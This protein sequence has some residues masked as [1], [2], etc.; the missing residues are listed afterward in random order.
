VEDEEA[1][2]SNPILTEPEDAAASP[3]PIR[4]MPDFDDD[5]DDAAC[6]DDDDESVATRRHENWFSCSGFGSP[7]WWSR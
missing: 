5:D 4:T 7:E 3:R 6:D 2:M 1:R